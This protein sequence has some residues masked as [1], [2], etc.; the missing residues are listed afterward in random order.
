MFIC[1]SCLRTFTRGLLGES[2]ILSTAAAQISTQTGYR[3]YNAASSTSRE[4]ATSTANRQHEKTAVI[5]RKPQEAEWDPNWREKKEKQIK[6]R[7]LLTELDYLRDPI[8]LA[9]DVSTR[10]QQN[11]YDRAL[12]LVRVAS[13][14]MSCVVS[15]NHL[16]DYNMA[17]GRIVPAL[18]T[19]QEVRRY[20]GWSL[21]ESRASI[22]IGF[23]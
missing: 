5:R 3:L 6:R 2:L 7:D 17:K 22:L 9:Q 23:R 4:Y 12:D 16:I 11:D 18:K 13:S 14:R 21:Q 15:W 20:F 10:L 8:V 1:S 19:Y